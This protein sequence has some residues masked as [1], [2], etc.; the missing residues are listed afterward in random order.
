MQIPSVP[1]ATCPS[2]GG[3]LHGPGPMCL[4]CTETVDRDRVGPEPHTAPPLEIPGFEI[5]REIGSG[6]M[7]TV[8][9][10]LDRKMQR[11][12]ALKVLSRHRSSEEKA[13]ERFAREAWIGG[14][15]S[16]PNLVK[17]YE[18][19]SAG[20]VIF[21]SMELCEGGSL[22]DVVVRM[23]RLGHD[24]RW[25]L[26][27]GT[28]DYVA[29]VIRQIIAV[30]GG[31][32]YAHRRGV[33]HRDVKPMNLLLT[34]DPMM[35]KIADFGL[36]LG[37]GVTRITSSQAV[38]GTVAFM[39]PEQI[40]GRR[41]AIDARTDVYALGVTLFE[42]LTLHLP[43]RGRTSEMYVNAVLNEAARHP[44]SLRKGL[45]RDIDV[46]LGKALEKD[47]TDRYRTAA[48]FAG[49]L[50]NV[51]A[52]KPIHARPPSPTARLMKW[53]RR[54]PLHATLAG[55]LLVG[56]P[57]GAYLSLRTAQHARLV[58]QIE[59]ASLLEEANRLSRDNQPRAAVERL[60][61][62][63]DLDSDHSRAL[64]ARS[65]NH[66]RI[67]LSED[68][69]A[70]R[71]REQDL[72]LSDA[73]RL[74]VLEPRAAWPHRLRA[75][76]LS[77]FGREEAA[78]PDLEEAARLRGASPPSPEEIEIDGTLA[79]EKGDYA[80]AVADFSEVIET[81]R[82]SSE[83]FFSRA[84]AH[85]ALGEIVKAQLDLQVA[86][87]LEPGNPD[88]L[89]ELASVSAL[90]GDLEAS[91]AHY[92]AALRLEPQSP[93][94]LTGLADLLV[95][96]GRKKAL[97][98]D[99]EGALR[100]FR[101]AQT[102][103][104]EAL[105]GDAS[106]PW[107]LLNLGASLMEENALLP[108]PDAKLIAMAL[109]HYE[110]AISAWRAAGGDP[111]AQEYAT[112]LT[113]VCDALIEL[114]DLDKAMAACAKVRELFPQRASAAYNLAGIHALMGR[115]EEAFSE[116]ER[117]FELGDRDHDYLAADDWFQSLRG[118]PRFNALLGRMRGG[119]SAP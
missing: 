114:R 28:R 88:A 72:A 14:R 60:S 25:D 113:N 58:T 118:D 80:K 52:F 98:G 6:G 40:R 73:S 108:S 61:G 39:A 12:V 103:A 17:V 99:A 85:R 48:D 37:E 9:E 93:R 70:A 15:L 87:A 29:W 18:M 82:G 97:A 110:G 59:I 62:I 47:P 10:A 36:A 11:R 64:R 89:Y 115:R 1:G 55:V 81:T 105:R 67:A 63:L 116:L 75:F 106:S 100:D 76:L 4:S 107:A 94:I 51:L 78:V 21:F 49:D 111:R 77:G 2:C 117:D 7:G 46:V 84:M 34:R 74:V 56:L 50:E 91:A 45:S 65:L 38:I 109:S 20:A 16:H 19:G 23:R 68:D 44:S 41:A 66:R 3:T 27:F 31:L 102:R 22:H 57:G 69:P 32:D 53:T 54:K 112:A 5:L 35:I 43:Y 92:R 26:E 79:I 101:S 90:A 71:R 42:L 13:E 30:A 33:V 24:E 95:R 104:A 96:R 86:A 8:Y 119:S 83:A